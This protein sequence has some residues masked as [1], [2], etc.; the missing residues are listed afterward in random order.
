MCLPEPS[1]GSLTRIYKEILDGFFA[2]YDF[3]EPIKKSSENLVNAT[4]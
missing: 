1:H 2:A 3:Y 4:I